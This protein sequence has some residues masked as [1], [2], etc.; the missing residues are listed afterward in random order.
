MKMVQVPPSDLSSSQLLVKSRSELWNEVKQRAE[1]DFCQAVDAT[2]PEVDEPDFIDKVEKEVL[3]RR[4]YYDISRSAF[5]AESVFRSS[6]K[7][8]VKM[9]AQP[10][11]NACN[12]VIQDVQTR[13]KAL[14][15]D[16][17]GMYPQL[18]EAC[19]AHAVQLLTPLQLELCRAVAVMVQRCSMTCTVPQDEIK[20]FQ[21]EVEEY[22]R[23]LSLT[24]KAELIEQVFSALPL[25][26]KPCQSRLILCTAKP[27]GGRYRDQASP[28]RSVN[29]IRWR[30]S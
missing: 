1:T 8:W 22:E 6:M 12:M 20:Q 30:Q 21:T 4:E 9:W 7:E 13:I 18:S 17:A 26:S 14:I 23:K 3:A 10:A 19:Q 16:V 11:V 29:Q 5:E 25:W 15:Q 24:Q 28:Q 27:P 2:C